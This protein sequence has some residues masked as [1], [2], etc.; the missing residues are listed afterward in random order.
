MRLRH[1]LAGREGG[2][3]PVEF[4]KVQARETF[5]DPEP[6]RREL[7]F[8]RGGLDEALSATIAASLARQ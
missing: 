8:G 5:F 6:A 4:I 1:R 2:L 3:D 7:D